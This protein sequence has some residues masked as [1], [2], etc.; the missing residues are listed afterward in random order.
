[1]SLH[2]YSDFSFQWWLNEL[3]S[4]KT[5]LYHHC[6]FRRKVS[7]IDIVPLK[8]EFDVAKSV[9]SSLLRPYRSFRIAYFSFTSMIV[10]LLRLLFNGVIN[11][12]LSIFSIIA[13]KSSPFR[14]DPCFVNNCDSW[15][16]SDSIQLTRKNKNLLYNFCIC[17][18]FEFIF[19]FS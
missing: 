5:L 10:K 13:D 1:M 7:C 8:L 9:C 15:K 3:R 6:F 17:D 11:S 2:Q 19:Y 4:Y 18:S 14:W 16:G 12:I